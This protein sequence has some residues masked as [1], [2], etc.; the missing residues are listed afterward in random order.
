MTAEIAGARPGPMVDR[1]EF[2]RELLMTARS[3]LLWRL[4]A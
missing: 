2:D 4:T 3:E 1:E